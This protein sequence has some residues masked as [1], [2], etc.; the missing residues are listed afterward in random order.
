MEGIIWFL[1]FFIPA[2]IT[3]MAPVFVRR[4]PVLDYPLDCNT[5]WRGKRL[6]GKNKTWR[7]LIFGI[8][9]GGLSGYIMQL[10]GLPFSWWWGL[11]LGFAALLGD[12]LES[13][14]KRQMNIK[15]G[16]RFMPWD[17]LDFIILAYAASLFF[18]DV[19]F[20]ASDVLL[21]FFLIFIAT[22]LVQIIGGVTKL[23]A[24]SL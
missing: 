6:F 15:P 21:G 12:A 22:V 24:N 23:K 20:R 1:V 10:A 19:N 13:M 18:V 8:V 2:Y 14:V 3:N 4:I 9:M 5:K 17:Q 11:I 7:G 16:G